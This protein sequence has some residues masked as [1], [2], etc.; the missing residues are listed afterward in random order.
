MGNGEA[1]EPMC[2]THGHELICGNDG[3]GGGGEVQGREE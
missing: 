2:M 1:R 3:G